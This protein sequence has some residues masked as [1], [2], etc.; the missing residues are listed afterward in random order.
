MYFSVSF[1]L[2]SAL[3]STHWPKRP[4]LLDL[5]RIVLC[6][7]TSSVSLAHAPSSL[8][9]K[10]WWFFQ[11]SFFVLSSFPRLRGAET[12]HRPKGEDCSQHLA[13][14]WLEAEKINRSL[15]GRNLEMGI[16]TCS[17]CSGPG[18]IAIGRARGADEDM[19]LLWPLRAVCLGCRSGS[20]SE[21]SNS[22][23]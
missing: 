9:L 18:C 10:L 22:W 19:L 21:A 1:L 3:V 13:A 16:F 17:L 20:V 2:L 6:R 5:T 23:F 11:A 14:G 7:W 15:R 8:S 12:H 4:P